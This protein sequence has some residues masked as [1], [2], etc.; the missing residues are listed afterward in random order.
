MET[1]I[2]RQGIGIRV[3]KGVGVGV[4]ERRQRPLLGLWERR[5]KRVRGLAR[6]KRTRLK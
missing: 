2:R 1:V 5:G 4:G 6:N 3:K